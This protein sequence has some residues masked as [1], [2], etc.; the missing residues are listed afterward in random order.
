MR[1]V[2]AALHVLV[3]L[4]VLSVP[5]VA[6]GETPADWTVMVFL[7]GSDLESRAA[8]ATA[9]LLEMMRAGSTDRIHVVVETLGTDVWGNDVVNP[10]TNQRF[11]VEQGTVGLNPVYLD[12]EEAVEHFAEFSRGNPEG[13]GLIVLEEDLGLRPVGD[14]E[15]L[16]DFIIWTI[17]R[18]P[19]KRYALILW[20]H[21]A[22]SVIGYGLDERAEPSTLTLAGLQHALAA[23]YARTGEVFELIGFDACLMATVEVA[24]VVS[25]YARYFVASQEFEP[26]S[27]WDYEA[28]LLALAADPSMDGAEWGRHIVD[29]YMEHSR[30]HAGPVEEIVTLSVTDLRKVGA[31]VEALERFVLAAAEGI[32]AP[33]RLRHFSHSRRKSESFGNG[34][35]FSYDMVDLGDLALRSADLYPQEAADVLAAIEDAVLYSLSGEGKNNASGLTIWLPFREVASAGESLADYRAQTPFSTVFQDFIEEYV[36]RLAELS[37]PIGLVSET[38]EVRIDEDGEEYYTVT[39]LPEDRD[40]LLIADSVLAYAHPAHEGERV[41]LGIVGDAEYDDETGEVTQYLPT[42]LPFISGHLISFFEHDVDGD[43]YEWTVPILLNG[44]EVDLI[45]LIWSVTMEG[46]IVGAWPGPIEEFDLASKETIPVQPGDVVAPLF[47]RVSEGSIEPEYVYFEE[48]IVEDELEF[49]WATP[50]EGEYMF[51]FVLSDLYLTETVSEFVH[52]AYSYE[53]DVED[54]DQ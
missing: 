18:F 8:A 39:I 25:P 51:A 35:Q 9:D 33:E 43:F 54:H 46:F 13:P 53:E 20:N 40:R 42:E 15:T 30:L 26:A 45:V 12:D 38:P 29:S 31:V 49:E 19:A 21:G 2:S 37:G 7:N 23:A 3:I 34:S 1:K 24:S 28:A 10:E 52:V 14:P 22:G 36:E 47:Q 6:L 17:E 5:S 48:F 11:Y 50:P 27:G 32:A 44:E 16:V 41:I 4:L